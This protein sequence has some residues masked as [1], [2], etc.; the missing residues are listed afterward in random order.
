MGFA[1][2]A[3]VHQGQIFASLADGSLMRLDTRESAWVKAGSTT[4]RVAHR[5]ASD[6]NAILLI[7]G[8]AKGKNLDLVEAV[9]VDAK[10]MTAANGR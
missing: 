5:L 4:P 8:A 10:Q 6:G 3:G 9:S 1:P 2:A 7:G